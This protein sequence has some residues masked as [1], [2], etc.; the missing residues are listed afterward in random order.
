MSEQNINI[1]EQN[2]SEENGNMVNFADMIFL[3]L[4]K[5]YW[6]LT[7]VIVCLIIAFLYVK[8]TPPT[9]ERSAAVLIKEDNQR[10]SGKAA[11]FAELS[12]IGLQSKVYNEILTLQ[13]PAIMSGVVKNLGIDV[14]YYTKGFFYDKPLY[15]SNLPYLLTFADME[16]ETLEG[17][18]TVDKNKFTLL[19]RNLDNEGTDRVITG[20]LLD[21]VKVTKKGKMVVSRNLSYDASN[22]SNAY[23]LNNPIIIS[24]QRNST[25]IESCINRMTAELADKNADVINLSY[26][27][28]SIERATDVVNTIIKVYNENWLREKNKITV[29]TSKFINERLQVIEKE[30]GSV[31]NSISSY[32]SSQ[33]IPDAQLAAGAYFEKSS[34]TSDQ[35]LDYNNRKSMA[36]YVRQQLSNNISKNMLLPANSGIENPSIEDQITEYNKDLLQRNNLAA[37]SNEQNPLI[38][39]TD[40]RIAQMRKMIM[41]SLDNYIYTLS[42]QIQTLERKEAMSNS[43]LSTNPTQA[44]YILSVERQQKVKESLYLYLLQKRE[45]N[46]VSQTFTAYNTRIINWAAGSDM[47]VAPSK[48]K[49]LAIAFVIGLAL[50]IGLIYLREMLNTTVR[51]QKDIENLSIPYIGEIPYAFKKK[52]K[53]NHLSA[54]NKL[55]IKFGFKKRKIDDEATRPIVVKDRKRDYVNE[56]F[57][58]V[59]ANLE[60][61]LGHNGEK[62][63]MIS[64]FNADSGKT[65]VGINLAV[66]YAIKGKKVIAID[67]DLRKATL[68]KNTERVKTGVEAYLNNDIQDFHGIIVKDTIHKHLDLMPCGTL[69]PNPSE[70]LYS[71]RLETM[72]KKLREEYDYIF[73]DC[74]PMEMLADAAIINKYA[75]LTAFIIRVELFERASLAKLEEIYNEKKYKN[76]A[77]ILNGS[78]PSGG[79]YGYGKYGYYSKYGYGYGYG[80]G[81][82]VSNDEKD[83]NE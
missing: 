68:S 30:L 33:R 40:A 22:E 18:L 4:N 71:P 42:S 13:S 53:E 6:I 69:P 54:T 38:V 36:N 29:S 20:N 9:Y 83:D 73:L 3:C 27:D 63:I 81:S 72:I 47:P 50:P 45:E 78:M 2:N 74:P 66:S 52:Q 44:K 48:G 51:G 23:I 34:N 60:F 5:W 12:G 17:E 79:R 19:I 35:L 62:V 32:K 70:L 57:R 16:S 49:I 67:L 55:L 75:D 15:G 43:Q 41:A 1:Q 58:V 14:N 24:K 46:E 28:V 56:A 8:R 25:T 76:L 21:S 10:S 59:R 31:D 7:S 26:K 37:N 80:Y 61:M 82:Y 65:F 64:S 11:E 39:E 77:I